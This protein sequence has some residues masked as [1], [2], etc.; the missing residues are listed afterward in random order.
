MKPRINII[1]LVA[2][3]LI[4]IWCTGDLMR[5]NDQAAILAGAYDLAH[6]RAQEWG[7][8]YQYDKTYVLYWTTSAI[9]KMQQ[10]VRCDADP[11]AAANMGLALA[12]WSA[13]T[14]FVV[15]FRNVLSPLVLLCFLTAPAVLLNTL[16][17]NSSVL[18]SAF[19]LL[20]TVFLLQKERKGGWL[21]ALF[22][23]LSV[24]SRA[25]IIL[26]LPLLLWIITPFPT[27]GTFF[28]SFSKPRKNLWLLSRQA[29]K[30]SAIF[31]KQWKLVAAGLAAL[32]AG[33]LLCGGSGVSL[34]LFFNAKMVVGYGVFG[35]GAAGLVFLIY[36][37][38]FFLW[39]L[40]AHG[41][42]EKAYLF[43]G[44]LALLLPVLFFLPQLHSPR[45]FWRA[46]EALLLLSASGRLSFWNRRGMMGAICLVAVIPLLVGVRLPALNRPQMTSTNPTLFPSGDGHYPMGGY[47]PF[48]FRLRNASSAPVDHNQRV[49]NAAQNT[50]FEENPA[51][52]VPVLITPMSGYLLFAAS[53]QGKT[54]HRS[55]FEAL[56]GS[57]F[58][59]DSRSLMR[60][61]PKT[62]LWALSQVLALPARFVSPAL[63]G[64]GVLKF[65]EGDDR[66]G[67]R[68]R[69][70]NRLF[71][72]NEY[73]VVS[74]DDPLPSDRGVVPFSDAPFEGARMDEPTG[75]YYGEGMSTKTKW[76]VM[77]HPNWM[78]LRTF[79]GGDQ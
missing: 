11:V 42:F 45:Y 44:F 23:A 60:D 36:A 33:P 4:S 72:G 24:G 13:L 37:V 57:A 65:G 15:R 69:L 48:M 30:G 8:Y 43:A 67:R 62:P 74:M 75:L 18:S 76:A 16:Y 7:A 25:D 50:V 35:F 77:V 29:L 61:D 26:L 71:A 2:I 73:F 64:L 70:L 28:S 32:V 19:L 54:A 12:F 68:T 14:V 56:S 20:S 49:W 38:R 52:E 78:S 46:C 3:A 39:I 41:G 9:F 53:L 59:A 27:L 6:G 40:R 31:S 66:W 1:L 22:F 51:G 55:S 58:Y 5:K 21:G 63:E 47:L 79:S 10:F 34:D 17:V